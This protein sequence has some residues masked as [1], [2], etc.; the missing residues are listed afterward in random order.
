MTEKKKQPEQKPSIKRSDKKPMQAL[1]SAALAIP[2]L[3]APVQA[4]APVSEPVLQYK[5]SAYR[6]ADLDQEKLAGGS[7][8]RFE[9]DSHQLR[10][11]TPVGRHTEV[12]VSLTHETM[13]GAS[14]WF[15]R[16][17]SEGQPIQIMT[18]ASIQD[19][20]T[21]LS[22]S[23]KHFVDKRNAWKVIVGHSTEDDYT[24]NNIGFEFEHELANQWLTLSA[25][26]GFSDDEME[27]TDGGTAT[28]IDKADKESLTGFIAASAIVNDLTIVQG[29]LGFTQQ[30]GYLSDPYKL[31]WVNGNII[32]ENRPEEREETRAEIRLRHYVL[33]ANAALHVDLRYFEDDWEVE[34]HTLNVAWYQNLPDGWQVTPSFRYYTQQQA[35]FYAP[36]FTR[37]RTDGHGSSDYRLAPY[38]AASARL[39]V[40]KSWGKL[41]TSFEYENYQ[42]D[43]D[44]SSR[45][46]EFEAP[47]LVDFEVFSLGV[48]WTFQ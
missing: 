12:D 2:G 20:R 29:S 21:D 41:S 44:L 14:P 10:Y 39:N 38:G 28:R 6:E 5:T 36:Y 3:V 45:S 9:I 34:S 19:S 11:L 25:G 22:V 43:A 4:A 24:A 15:V 33:P 17:D 16:P 27:P 48:S 18:G 47:G 35:E 32:Q 1:A 31:M 30:E 26:L 23:A 7:A 40:S 42:S 46:V 8:K 37:A 13:S